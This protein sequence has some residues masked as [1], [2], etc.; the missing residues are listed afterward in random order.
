MTA[1]ARR[2]RPRARLLIALV[3]PAFVGCVGASSEP[4][5]AANT[6][7]S[8][9]EDRWRPTAGLTWQWQLTGGLNLDLQTDVIDVDLDV[10]DSVIDY[11][12]SR[13][14]RVIC[15]ISVGSYERWR[16]DADRFPREILGK[17]YEGWSGERWLDIRRIDL[18]GPIMEARLDECAAKGFD[19]VE[20]DNMQIHDN[21]TGFPL[22]YRDQLRYALWLADEAHE[23]GLAIGQKNA[24]DM[25]QDL[26]DAYVFAITEDAFVH[27]WA[28]EMRV[29]VAA[30]EPVF[31]AEYTD[32]DADFAAACAR[33][34]ELGFSTILKDRELSASMEPCP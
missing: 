7:G 33:S 17:A 19:G 30:N 4:S 20:P 28:D 25:T 13:G 3:A 23:R 15:Y 1:A 12:H 34:D 21:D 2:T 6:A 29:Y 31:A 24:P 27:G 26:V 22:T 9:D 8:A 11:Y 16:D 10:G 14:T 5:P 32:T 18:L